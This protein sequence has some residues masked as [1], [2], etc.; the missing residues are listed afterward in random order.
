MSS[1]DTEKLDDLAQQVWREAVIDEKHKERVDRLR[2]SMSE[3]LHW[4]RYVRT[5]K[6]SAR[7]IPNVRMPNQRQ[8]RRDSNRKGGAR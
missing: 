7:G 5:R 2:R 8:R 4:P 6:P 1:S 3:S